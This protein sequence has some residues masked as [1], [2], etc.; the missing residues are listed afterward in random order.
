MKSKVPTF[1][2]SAWAVQQYGA[3]VRHT[4]KLVRPGEWCV[5]RLR[6]RGL[7]ALDGWMLPMNPP[8]WNRAEEQYR[9]AHGFRARTRAAAQ[10][11]VS[12]AGY[13]MFGALA[14]LGA[15]ALVLLGM[16]AWATA[17]VLPLPVLA[18]AGAAEGVH[19]LHAHALGGAAPKD[20]SVTETQG[21]NHDQ[22]QIAPLER[23]HRMANL[24]GRGSKGMRDHRSRVILRGRGDQSIDL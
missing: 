14:S 24:S 13:G 18:V 8:A 7:C 17:A 9:N 3:Y 11:A 21:R 19:Q 5:E 12:Y 6:A 22:L 10:C 15:A 2:G 23:E 4:A 1:R 16:A 20:S